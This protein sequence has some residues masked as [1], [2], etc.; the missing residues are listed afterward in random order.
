MNE[1][2]DI[3]RERPSGKLSSRRLALLI[4]IA[5]LSWSVGSISLKDGKV[6]DVPSGTVAVIG[7]LAAS[8]AY[9]RREQTQRKDTNEPTP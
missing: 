5:P 4:F 9:Q 1:L 7:I 6:A 2:A 8:T 3:L